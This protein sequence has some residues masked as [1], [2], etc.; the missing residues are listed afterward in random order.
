MS[1][2]DTVNLWLEDLRGTL[3]LAGLGEIDVP[4]LLATVREIAHTVIH[5]AGPIALL[6]IGYAAGQAGGGAAA[7]GQLETQVLE[8]AR[9]FAARHPAV[10]DA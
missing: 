7:V 10:R 6:A 1:E 4:Q 9:T 3:D 2:F 5:P 8:L